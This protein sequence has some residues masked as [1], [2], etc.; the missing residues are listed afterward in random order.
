[1]NGQKKLNSLHN[2]GICISN[3]NWALFQKV[4][5]CE[6]LTCSIDSILLVTFLILITRVL[7]L[8]LSFAELIFTIV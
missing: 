4:L 3:H 2:K 8:F 5:I 6:S 1:M 7:F